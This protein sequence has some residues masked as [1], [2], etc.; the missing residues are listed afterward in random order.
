VLKYS[1]F[2]V[3]ATGAKGIASEKAGQSQTRMA[4]VRSGCNAIKHANPGAIE[5]TTTATLTEPP[6]KK[7]RGRLPK[8]TKEKKADTITKAKAKY[9]ADMAKL[10]IN[11]DL[12]E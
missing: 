8:S 9:K 4:Y 2:K 7:R 6:A 10:S 11:V 5:N 3:S 1:E 12:D